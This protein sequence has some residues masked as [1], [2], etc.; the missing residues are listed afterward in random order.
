MDYL[1]QCFERS[2]GHHGT[3]HTGGRG[4]DETD[5]I[6][7]TDTPQDPTR[8]FFYS[9][10]K[11]PS[12][13]IAEMVKEQELDDEEATKLFE[14][15][16]RDL[17]TTTILASPELS[18]FHEVVGP[19]ERVRPHRH[20]TTQIT[21]VLKGELRYGNRVTTAG[22]GYFSPNK[23]YSWTAGGPPPHRVSAPAAQTKL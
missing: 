22:M 8:P 18:V 20:G 17:L 7:A 3:D 4:M 10:G 21:Y 9:V 15:F 6:E 19:G 13:T 2:D 12:F 11:L 23:P 16:G 1:V 14:L 5:E